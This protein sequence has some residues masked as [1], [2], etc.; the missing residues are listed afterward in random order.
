MFKVGDLVEINPLMKCA[1][2]QDNLGLYNM[3]STFRVLKVGGQIVVNIDIRRSV[4]LN[5]K[6]YW[7]TIELPDGNKKRVSSLWLV[8]V[9]NG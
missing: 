4:N 9:A 1:A 6:D 8:K 2:L 5:E 7:V 3:D